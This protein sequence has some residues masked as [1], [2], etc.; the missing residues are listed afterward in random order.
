MC[1]HCCN[2]SLMNSDCVLISL[3]G[4]A[5]RYTLQPVFKDLKHEFHCHLKLNQPQVLYQVWFYVSITSVGFET[6]RV[7]RQVS[8][9]DIANFTSGRYGLEFLT[10]EHNAGVE[11]H[12]DLILTGNR[13]GDTWDHVVSLVHDKNSDERRRDGPLL[14]SKS[15]SLNVHSIN[16]Q[17]DVPFAYSTSSWVS[18]KNWCEKDIR[19]FRP[20]DW[21]TSNWSQTVNVITQTGRVPYTYVLKSVDNPPHMKFIIPGMYQVLQCYVFLYA[22][23]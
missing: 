10:I 7:F 8:F 9:N 23:V 13:S 12:R 20:V 21:K 4:D 17:F 14:P 22:C 11:L 5:Y 16:A 3:P 15:H 1:L 2:A 18:G 19:K 6:P